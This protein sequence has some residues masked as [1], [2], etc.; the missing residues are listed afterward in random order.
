MNQQQTAQNQID[1]IEQALVAIQRALEQDKAD[2]D[3]LG[4]CEIGDL[5][6]V[7]DQLEQIEQFWGG[8]DD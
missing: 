8:S 6:Y 5:G 3:R 1:R 7:A 4:W 2:V